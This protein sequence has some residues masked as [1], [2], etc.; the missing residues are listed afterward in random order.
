MHLYMDAIWQV[1]SKP[2]KARTSMYKWLSSKMDIPFEETH[3]KYFTKEQC[4]KAIK[5]LKPIYIQLYG[6]DLPWRK[7]KDV[8]N[9]KFTDNKGV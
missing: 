9:G 3:V 6:K 2:K 5:I 7:E 4:K 8:K 1:S